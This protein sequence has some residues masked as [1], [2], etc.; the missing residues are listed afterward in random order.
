MSNSAASITARGVPV[1]SSNTRMDEGQ[2]AFRVA[3]VGE[4]QLHAQAL[5][6]QQRRFHQYVAVLRQDLLPGWH[7]GTTFGRCLETVAHQFD[8]LG[9]RQQ[10]GD[11]L[12]G[13][14]AEWHGVDRKRYPG[15]A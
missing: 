9:H 10:F 14:Q 2:S 15:S 11:L 6:G 5:V 8:R 13:N 12:A 7:F 3:G 1:V 4:D